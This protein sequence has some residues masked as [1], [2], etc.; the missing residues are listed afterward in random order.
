MVFTCASVVMP[1][2]PPPPPPPPSPPVMLIVDIPETGAVI[3][4]I[5]APLKSN[6]VTP[7]P[8]VPPEVLIPTP[9]ITPERF[10]P[11]P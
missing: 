3:V 6:R 7:N 9:A 8:T 5:P 1:D 2:P 11:S 4:E 10:D